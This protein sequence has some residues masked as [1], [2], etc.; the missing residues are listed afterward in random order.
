VI[1]AGGN[2]LVKTDLAI[3]LPRGCY[4]RISPRSGLAIHH[5][6]NVGGGVIDED[7]HDNLSMIL[8]NHSDKPFHIHHGDR[9]AQLICQNIFYPDLEEVQELDET[10]RGN[11]GFGST[12][13]N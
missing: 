4:G 9:V 12:G 1:P 2:V 11:N 13:C 7:F 10:E 6:I 3:Q 5:H 8:F